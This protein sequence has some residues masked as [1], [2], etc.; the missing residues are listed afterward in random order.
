MLHDWLHST[1]IL[2]WPDVCPSQQRGCWMF[3][4]IMYDCLQSS[5]SHNFWPPE[6]LFQYRVTISV[7]EG[8]I[9]RKRRHSQESFRPLCEYISPQSL[10]CILL[11]VFIFSS[12][13]A[14]RP[15]L[16]STV[17]HQI[18]VITPFNLAFSFMFHPCPEHNGRKTHLMPIF[19]AQP[20]NLTRLDYSASL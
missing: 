11:L 9:L 6:N 1:P 16:N 19:V 8:V 13:S 15:H 7:Q 3:P 17:F 5:P 20:C 14:T 4:A 2:H 18:A 12:A 10:Q